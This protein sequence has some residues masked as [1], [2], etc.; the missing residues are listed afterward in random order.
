MDVVIS[1]LVLC[2]VNNIDMTLRGNSYTLLARTITTIFF[3]YDGRPFESHQHVRGLML[4][5]AIYKYR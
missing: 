5:S 4:V 3:F 1:T 2:S